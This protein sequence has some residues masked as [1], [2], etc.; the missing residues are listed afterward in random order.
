MPIH[1][2][3]GDAYPAVNFSMQKVVMTWK[4]NCHEKK[5]KEKKNHD[6]SDQALLKAADVC[7]LGE[8]FRLSHMAG[9]LCSIQEGSV[10]CASPCRLLPGM[11]ECGIVGT[12]QEKKQTI[13]TTG[14]W[15]HL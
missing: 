14:P 6:L 3:S 8:R 9:D 13:M 10:P 1:L 2:W 12:T 7:E 11:E 4:S 5:E 15:Q